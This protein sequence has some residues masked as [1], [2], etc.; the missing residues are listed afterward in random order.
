MRDFNDHFIHFLCSLLFRLPILERYPNIFNPK[1]HSQIL[2]RLM[3]LDLR[4]A[5]LWHIINPRF[6][7]SG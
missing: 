5:E 3:P 4:S 1:L 2:L 6:Y 7:R